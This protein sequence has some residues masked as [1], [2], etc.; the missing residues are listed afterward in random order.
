MKH[1]YFLMVSIT[2]SLIFSTSTRAQ[3][4]EQ[5]ILSAEGFNADIIAEGEG[6][7][8]DAKSNY[9]IDAEGFF[10]NILY[11]EDFVPENPSNVPTA[12]D[13]GG[14]LPMDGNL[15]SESSGVEYQFAPYDGNNAVLLRNTLSNSVTLNFMGDFSAKSLYLATLSSE[16]VHT[17]NYTLT[18]SDNTTQT[19]SFQPLDWYQLANPDNDIV[20]GLGR[21]SRGTGS[22][23]SLNDFSSLGLI[24]IFEEII[25]I[26][27]QNLGKAFKSIKFDKEET[28]NDAA[29]SAI[30]AISACEIPLLGS[31]DNSMVNSFG[32]YP[33]PT[34]G[35][36]QLKSEKNI[37]ACEVFDLAGKKLTSNQHK[38]L[39][40]I[41]LS[42]MKTGV[43]LIKVKLENGQVETF[44]INKK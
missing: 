11:S 24:T 33:N 2:F 22:G 39:Q 30:L 35:L 19:G 23:S 34:T 36:V 29:T 13:F 31:S 7:D 10:A 15:I 18:F 42:T 37:I 1:F 9:S 14:G 5:L 17:V 43:Y 8:A 40:Q 32:Y 21:V 28:E 44:K 41:D 25:E 3:D 4:C 20:Y 16:G 27:E 12:S 6:G 26:D 38:N